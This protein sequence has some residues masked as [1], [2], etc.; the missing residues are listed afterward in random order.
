MTKESDILKIVKEDILRIL[1]EEEG[2][3]MSL[4]SIELEIKVSNLFLFKAVKELEKEGLIESER[5]FILLTKE[6][7]QKAKNIIKNHLVLENY[8]KKT[9][10]E[11][12]AHEA[13]HIL[14]HYVSKEVVDDIKELSTLK[15]EGV[16]LTKFPLKK[17]GIITD[18]MFSDYELF[19]RIVSMGMYIGEKIRITNKIPNAFIIALENKKFALDKD[20]AKGI[21]VLRCERA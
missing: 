15:K 18:I 21:K 4:E 16:P 3:K 2:K 13:A 6:G 20:I 12:E 8:F 14:E 11:R 19:E 9:R 1:G 7:G 17:E 10:G 5:N